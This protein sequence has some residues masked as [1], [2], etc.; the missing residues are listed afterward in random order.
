L[1]NLAVVAVPV[2]VML[3]AGPAL[4]TAGHGDR[5]ITCTGG[6]IASGVYTD[7]IVTGQ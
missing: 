7:I 3:P 1:K 5:S 4:A 6:D 2:A